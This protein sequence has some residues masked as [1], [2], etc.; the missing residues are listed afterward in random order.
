[1]KN[2]MDFLKLTFLFPRLN[3]GSIPAPIGL[4]A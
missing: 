2:Y 3:G 1:M 4:S